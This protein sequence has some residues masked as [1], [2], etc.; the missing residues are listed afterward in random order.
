[1]VRTTL[2]TAAQKQ[3]KRIIEVNNDLFLQSPH[4][5]KINRSLDRFLLHSK[6]NK[7]NNSTMIIISINQID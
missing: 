1:M 5:F 4:L 2:G 6:Q 3:L 7:E